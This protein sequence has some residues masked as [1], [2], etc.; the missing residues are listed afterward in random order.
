MINSQLIQ[1]YRDIFN[2]K[3][4]EVL[5]L[6][7]SGTTLEIVALVIN[8]SIN[9]VRQLE[10]KAIV[11]FRYQLGRDAFKYWRNRAQYD[12]EFVESFKANVKNAKNLSAK[13]QD[14][15]FEVVETNQ[16]F[17]HYGI[18]DVVQAVWRLQEE[19]SERDDVSS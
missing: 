17:E 7:N 4:L 9:K 8:M 12:V 3:E 5:M 6:R 18:Q 16:L 11:K 10:N 19:L 2:E 15:L 14:I 1:N 13:D